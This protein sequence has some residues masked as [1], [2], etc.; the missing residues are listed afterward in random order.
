MPQYIRIAVIALS[1]AVI[2]S[3]AFAQGNSN[4]SNGVPHV[5]EEALA[6][7]INVEVT[8][9]SPIEVTVSNFPDTSGGGALVC[10]NIFALL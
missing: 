10:L 5:I 3:Q 1:S 6:N 8:N 2:S 9:E 4:Q 7:G